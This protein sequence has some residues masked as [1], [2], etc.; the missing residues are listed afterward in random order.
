MTRKEI[1]EQMKARHNGCPFFEERE[2]ASLDELTG[3]IVT[4]QDFYRFTEKKKE[5]EEKSYYA[6]LFLEDKEHVYLSGG[7]L[8]SIIDDYDDEVI[9][10]Q[11]RLESPIKVKSDPTHSY[12]PITVMDYNYDYLNTVHPIVKDGEHGND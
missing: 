7:G 1:L 11:V 10:L 5:G 2:K 3:H 8:T 4:I 12:R 6:V 9:G